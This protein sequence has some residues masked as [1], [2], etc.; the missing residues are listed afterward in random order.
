MRKRKDRAGEELYDPSGEIRGVEIR[1]VMRGRVHAQFSREETGLGVRKSMKDRSAS[2]KRIVKSTAIEKYRRIRESGICNLCSAPCS[3]CMHLNASFTESKAGDDY[4]DDA[5]RLHLLKSRACDDGRHSASEASNLLST[6]SSHDSFTENAQSKETMR[7]HDVPEGSEDGLECH[8]DN[9]SCVTGM[10]EESLY[11]PVAK[12]KSSGIMSKTADVFFKSDSDRSLFPSSNDVHACDN[13]PTSQ[14]PHCYSQRRGSLCSL[15]DTKDSEENSSSMVDHSKCFTEPVDPLPAGPP[16]SKKVNTYEGALECIN[17]SPDTEGCKAGPVAHEMSVCVETIGNKDVLAQSKPTTSFEV[18]NIQETQTKSLPVSE[19]EI[20]GSDMMEDD[21]KIQDGKIFLLFA[22]DAVMVLSTLPEGDWLCEECQLKEDAENQRVAEA[23]KKSATVKALSLNEKNKDPGAIFIPKLPSKMDMR[24]Q[25][26]EGNQEIKVA[27]VPKLPAKR[28]ADNLEASVSKR[29]AVE[30]STKLPSAASP[31]KRPAL[32]RES[33]FKKSDVGK[34][35]VTHMPTSPASHSHNNSQEFVRSAAALG[36]NSSM[37][38][39]LLKSPQGVLSRSASM[40]NSRPKLKQI[41]EEVTQKKKLETESSTRGTRMRGLMRSISRSQS[42][43]VISSSLSNANESR[44]RSLNFSHHEDSRGSKQTKEQNV[45]ERKNSFKSDCTTVSSAH[46]VSPRTLFRAESMTHSSNNNSR[47]SKSMNPGRKLS[48]PSDPNASISKK[49]SENLSPSVTKPSSKLSSV[50]SFLNGRCHAEEP[51]RCQAGS[52]DL[53]TTGFSHE[54]DKPVNSMERPF[55]DGLLQQESTNQIGKVKDAFSLS[56]SR[57]NVSSRSGSKCIRCQICSEV[58]HAAEFCTAVSLC[59]SK[60]FREATNKSRLK[61]A[62]ETVM[63]RTRMHKYN[64]LDDQHDLSLPRTGLS[65]EITAKDQL[66]SSSQLMNFSSPGGTLDEKEVFRSSS[67]D[68]H[69]AKSAPADTI[70]AGCADTITAGIGDNMDDPLIFYESKMKPFKLSPPSQA[71]MVAKL[72]KISAIPECDF[73]WH[74]LEDVPIESQFAATTL[75]GYEKNYKK[76]MGNILKNDLALRGNIDGIELLIFPSSQLP[77]KSQQT[78]PLSHDLPVL[79]ISE[80]AASKFSEGHVD[81]ELF[82]TVTTPSV[83]EAVN[84]GLLFGSPSMKGNGET[85]VAGLSLD[86]KL[87]VHEIKESAIDESPSHEKKSAHELKDSSVDPIQPSEKRTSCLSSSVEG[88]GSMHGDGPTHNQISAFHE[89][90][91]SA[92][93][94]TT[95]EKNASYLF[96][97]FHP[98]SCSNQ[99]TGLIETC[100]TP[101]VRTKN[102]QLHSELYTKRTSL[103]HSEISMLWKEIRHPVRMVD[104]FETDFEDYNR[105]SVFQRGWDCRDDTTAIFISSIVGRGAGIFGG[106]NSV[107]LTEDTHG[108]DHNGQAAQMR[109][110]VSNFGQ[111]GPAVGSSNGQDTVSVSSKM[112]SVTDDV[113]EVAVTGSKDGGRES[114]VDIVT[115]LVVDVW[116]EQTVQKE[117]TLKSGRK[118]LHRN[119]AEIIPETCGDTKMKIA[120]P[121]GKHGVVDCILV[122]ADEWKKTRTTCPQEQDLESR[123][124]PEIL[125]ESGIIDEER[126]GHCADNSIT[127]TSTNIKMAERYSFPVDVGP[128]RDLISGNSIPLQILSSDDED[129]LEPDFPS[130]ELALGAARKPS[131]KGI[132]P[133]FVPVADEKNNLRKLSDLMTDGGD[134]DMSASLSLSLA[135][136]SFGKK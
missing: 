32:S 22:A 69:G 109:M 48:T 129:P 102:L 24:A 36:P 130:L 123:S 46:V 122:D 9:I 72:P 58:G 101:R 12:E 66:K 68:F 21:V 13:L 97:Q 84:S 74:L 64:R 136:P 90:N 91:E 55:C 76:L 51:E 16:A 14:F 82:G 62:V 29:Q 127:A 78:N 106:F 34:V 131:K 7:N 89:H 111:A 128:V 70:T 10:K 83:P 108:L 4:S 133:L 6:T 104:K 5:G 98:S 19:C 2:E 94:D 39:V 95:F 124:S 25:E 110:E 26:L 85:C 35:K 18:S 93:D 8:G 60:S 115:P 119:L 100:S 61:D 118:C 56:L 59:D 132:L 44:C 117:N 79:A 50:I 126:Q 80:V 3:S 27:I 43:K 11:S 88:V 73:I 65:D 121:L 54:D 107:H 75:Q 87:S 103:L 53:K 41:V 57:S 33:S 67:A 125:V 120:E 113:T 30:T 86:Q 31:N 112:L 52:K 15:G 134:D 114:V 116:R 28:L 135:F 71:S 47:D 63:S 45:M 1:S 49:G 20:Y 42:F 38:Q 23:E 96:P 37:M 17:I 77:L 105:F 40:N 81:Q 99:L 92:V